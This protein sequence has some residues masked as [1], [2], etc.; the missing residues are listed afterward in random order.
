[1]VDRLTPPIEPEDLLDKAVTPT[2][3]PTA[4]RLCKLFGTA[5]LATLLT[6][7][8]GDVDDSNPGTGGADAG[9]QPSALDCMARGYNQPELITEWGVNDAIEMDSYEP[10]SDA[11][12]NPNRILLNHTGES[13]NDQSTFYTCEFVGGSNCN[14]TLVPSPGTKYE[15][16]VY[17]YNQGQLTYNDFKMYTF[18]NFVPET[19]E[20]TTME[21]LAQGDNLFMQVASDPE[22]NGN[23]SI[24][25]EVSPDC[26]L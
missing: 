17:Y 16:A 15:A 3:F 7:C 12:S 14:F 19:Q 9:V 23:Y 25:I 2:L 13:P 5:L 10:A 22:G 24:S 11:D 21:P 26:E 4:P 20:N 8:S 18:E 6:A 1:M